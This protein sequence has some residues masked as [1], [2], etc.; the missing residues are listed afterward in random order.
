MHLLEGA[1]LNN[2]E[3][4]TALMC[5]SLEYIFL[6]RTSFTFINEKEKEGKKNKRYLMIGD[7]FY[8]LGAFTAAKTKS[9]PF[10][11]IFSDQCVDTSNVIVAM[12]NHLQNLP[13]KSK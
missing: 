11:K 3:E 13:I 8:S 2:T 1:M 12:Q 7:L 6:G 9:L 10:Y 5:L 4:K